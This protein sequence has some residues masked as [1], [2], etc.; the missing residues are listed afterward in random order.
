MEEMIPGTPIIGG[1]PGASAFYSK[2]L[3]RSFVTSNYLKRFV[4]KSAGVL[5]ERVVTCYIG[6]NTEQ[7]APVP[8]L[9]SAV[10][11]HLN[12]ADGEIVILY[13]CRIEA[14][15]QP[16]VFADAII[17]LLRD[18]TVVDKKVNLRILVAGDGRLLGRLQYLLSSYS[19]VMFLGPAKKDSVLG[20]M[21][22]ADIVFLP[23]ENEGV[24]LLQ[25]ETMASGKVFV[26][27]LV[28]GQGEVITPDCDCGILVK[29]IKDKAAEASSKSI[30][31]LT[32]YVL[33]VFA[34][35]SNHLI[36][37][38]NSILQSAAR[39]RDRSRESGSYRI[40]R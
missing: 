32:L 7:F 17:Q 11:Q 19:K 22:A 21:Q 33:L 3:H 24:S 39:P 2:Y 38:L 20:L 14:Q 15:K 37:V 23:S 16:E 13:A 40:E 8:A 25:F 27:A 30:S 12:I 26:G 35:L 5:P 10:R 4:Q 9:R 1:Y 31:L 6:T 29:P 34:H 18:S 36:I 28:G